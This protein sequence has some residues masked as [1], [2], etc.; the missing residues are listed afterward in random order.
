MKKEN[1]L[2]KAAEKA[3]GDDFIEREKE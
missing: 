1:F 2:E 3:F